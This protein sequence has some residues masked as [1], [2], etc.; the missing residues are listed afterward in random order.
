VSSAVDPDVARTVASGRETIGEMVVAAR[1]DLR[2]VFI[3]FVIGLLGTVYLLRQFI[4][5]R[6]RADLNTNP[7]IEIIAVTPFDVILLQVKIGLVVGILFSLPLMIYYGRDPLRER[8]LWPTGLPRWKL[9]VLGLVAAALF[10]GGAAYAYVIFFPAMF[11]FLASNAVQAGFEP[12]YSIVKW[13][14]FI[15]LLTLSFGLAA[16][17]PLA[18]S[19]LAYGGVVRYETFR[20]R[21]KY[22]V[23]GIFAFG[24]LFSPPDP[25]TQIMWATPLLLLYAISLGFTRLVVT[26]QRSNRELDV[27]QVALANWNLLAGGAF[28]AGAVIYVAASV[29]AAGRL[30]PYAA[31]IGVTVPHPSPTLVIALAVVAA[32]AGGGVALAYATIRALDEAEAARRAAA[33]ASAGAPGE[34]DVMELDARSIGHAPPQAFTGMTEDEVVELAGRAIEEGDHEKAQALLDRFDEFSEAEALEDVGG[35]GADDEEAETGSTVTRTSAGMLN[36]FTDEEI[37][38]DDVGG[39]YY[40]IA[41]VLD[42]LTSKAFWLVGWFMLVL[43][44]SFGFLYQGG[45]RDLK[46]IFLS[47][48]P[49]TVRPEQVQI[50][51]LHPVEAL[52]FEVKV[53]TI[54]AAFACLPLLLYFAWPALKERGFARGDRRVILLWGGSLFVGIGLGIGVGF[55]TVAPA[56]IS[57]LTADVIQSSMVIAYQI[58]S[59]GWLVFFTTVGVGLL[60]D[61]PV[62]MLLFVAGDLVSY[63]AFRNRWREVTVAVFAIVAV[64]SPRGVFMMFIIGVPVMLA[65]AAGLALAWAYTVLSGGDG[66]AEPEVDP[67]D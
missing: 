14:Q 51:T 25:F 26:A 55:L 9:A 48:L 28:L 40:D 13:T 8:G 29:V 35:G 46:E 11:G 41:F 4:W 12:T 27:R 50:V 5:D 2:K 63:R 65:Y 42:S 37:D 45:I 32:L 56:I 7:N 30:D 20:D 6:L 62:T 24:A 58:N 16:Q 33:P 17:L 43:A 61:I 36:A 52:V 19:G 23:V 49:E 57:W 22:A 64:A 59:F 10:V 38:E 1:S 67:A 47:R 53:S 44:A 3:L 34:I 60:F 15:F 21:W 18:M 31:R 66:G 39:Y 54:V